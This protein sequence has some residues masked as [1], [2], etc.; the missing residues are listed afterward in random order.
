MHE[1]SIASQSK[2]WLMHAKVFKRESQTN[3]AHS[4][5][6][7]CQK[8]DFI[9]LHHFFDFFRFLIGNLIHFFSYF[10]CCNW[11]ENSH[12]HVYYSHHAN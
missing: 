8:H 7:L 3:N 4:V 11:P 9:L 10:Y 12:H 2:L 6:V 5:V 1:H